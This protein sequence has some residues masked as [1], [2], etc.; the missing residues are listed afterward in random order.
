[1]LSWFLIVAITTVIFSDAKSPRGKSYGRTFENFDSD[2]DFAKPTG[3]VKSGIGMGSILN[4]GRKYFYELRALTSSEFEK[5]CMKATRPDNLNA[6]EKHIE[7]IIQIID[8]FQA[9]K[10]RCSYTNALHIVWCRMGDGDARTKL[11]AVYLLHRLWRTLH[12]DH[13]VQFRENMK[14]MKQEFCSQTKSS[15][16]YDRKILDSRFPEDGLFTRHYVSFVLYRSEHFSASFEEM[17]LTPN[18]HV[19]DEREIVM[20]LKEAKRCLSYLLQCTQDPEHAT[21]ITIS[22]VQLL[23]EDL[24]VLVENFQSRLLDLISGELFGFDKDGLAM[25]LITT[26]TDADE[27]ISAKKKLC[28]FFLNSIELIDSWMLTQGR[29]LRKFG[30]KTPFGT[31][32]WIRADTVTAMQSYL[33]Q[34]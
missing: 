9:N 16:F 6:K 7:K 4:K 15:Y 20:T 13:I 25:P 18:V 10:N 27:T 17:L 23:A 11:K 21:D 34:P 30:Y 1:M 14:S 5:S 22:C 32:D 3:R 31:M 29:L 26:I 12:Y 33:D 8:K 28:S 19:A 2:D 24:H